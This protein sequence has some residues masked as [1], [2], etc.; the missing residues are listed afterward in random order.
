ME[1]YSVLY[2]NEI[3]LFAG[4]WMELENIK[5]SEI[6]L[7]KPKATGFLSYMD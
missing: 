7:R 5:L 3:L 6:R 1:V 2:Q 4:K